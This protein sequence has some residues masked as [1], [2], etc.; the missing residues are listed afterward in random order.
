MI[1]PGVMLLV[2]LLGGCPAADPPRAPL[3][4]VTPFPRARPEPVPARSPRPVVTPTPTVAPSL[5]PAP[6]P[7]A[8]PPRS[9]RP[10]VPEFYWGLDA[11]FRF[12]GRVVVRQ[13]VTI[14]PAPASPALVGTTDGQGYARMIFARR[15]LP[16]VLALAVQGRAVGDLYLEAGQ[17][18]RLNPQP[19]W[20]VE[21]G[22]FLAEL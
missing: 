5:A 22:S 2:G 20:A 17:A 4:V 13:D 1:R 21:L 18:P 15:P 19:G 10:G 16:V 8:T 14:G 3:E 11:T 9:P 12:E 6:V 7:T